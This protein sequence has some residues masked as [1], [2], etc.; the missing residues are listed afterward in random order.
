MYC[1]PAWLDNTNILFKYLVHRDPCLPHSSLYLPIWRTPLSDVNV[2]L[3]SGSMV[4]VRDR[5]SLPRSRFLDVTQ[6]S[7]A[8][9]DIQKT[10]ARET[11]TELS[12]I[13]Y[14]QNLPGKFCF[15]MLTLC[16][17]FL[18]WFFKALPPWAS[19]SSSF[20][21]R[22]LHWRSADWRPLSE[23]DKRSKVCDSS[24]CTRASWK[25]KKC[26]AFS[27]LK[28]YKKH[29]GGGGGTPTQVTAMIKGYFWVPEYFLGRNIWQVFFRMALF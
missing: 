10:A 9:R 5:V 18:I 21:S 27:P 16:S 2:V 13:T 28:I 20:T 22:S 14:Y 23:L 7:G 11:K 12:V 1:D 15:Q 24:C 6:R 19:S 3:V 17:N 4:S 8:L 26:W 29:T 25:I